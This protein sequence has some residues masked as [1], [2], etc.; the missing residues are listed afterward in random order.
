M[1]RR[2]ALTLSFVVLL[3][4]APSGG[5]ALGA[6]RVVAI[7]ASDPSRADARKLALGISMPDGRDLG[8][9][10]DF[11]ASIG[12]TR[13][14]TWTI[15]R[16]WGRAAVSAFPMAAAEGARQRGAVPIIW[17]EPISPDDWSDTTYTR[18][19][20]IVDGLHDD[21]IRQFALDAKAYG[22][23]VLLRFAHQ[24]N[25]DY[26]PWAWD[27]S[28]TDD[29]TVR[30]FKRAW[31]HVRRIF[32]DVGASNVKFV[33]T[34]ATQTCAG[35]CLKRPLGFPGRRWV[36]YLGFTWENWGEAGPDPVT[37]SEPWTPML[38]GF[39]PI[40][41]RLMAV[42]RKP[43]MAV[44]VASGPDGGNKARWIRNGYPKIYRR[45]PR[46]KAIMYLNVDLS[47]PP[48]LH[49]DWSL[50]GAA[51]RAYADIAS[52]RRFKGRIR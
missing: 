19:Q 41:K 14:A 17:W 25:S 8:E 34:I 12:G 45:L 40:V 27:Y 9:L 38:K 29:N 31:R 24:A 1:Q 52:Q 16:Q 2:S 47:G 15:W 18:H 48:H 3:A 26:L 46:V 6:Q 4:L 51:L 39:T 32:R 5:L 20:N 36:D 42:S 33:W 35:N 13:V 50:S 22:H 28:P 43:I 37:P 23:R 49:R 21:Y 10:D 11:R 7:P 30:T 44:A